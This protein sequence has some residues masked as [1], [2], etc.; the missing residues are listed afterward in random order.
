MHTYAC[1]IV[2]LREH[3]RVRATHSYVRVRARDCM[4]P[5]VRT[6]LRVSVLVHENQHES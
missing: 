2:R 5:F 6:R 4:P 3:V 1:A